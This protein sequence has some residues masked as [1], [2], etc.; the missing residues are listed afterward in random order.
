M[1]LNT[2]NTL[3]DPDDFYEELV[4][5]QRGMDDDQATRL[6]AKLVLLL[7][8]QVGDREVLSQAIRRAVDSTR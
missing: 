6:L 7:A 1:S 3:N 5:A 2:Q 8:N 4:A